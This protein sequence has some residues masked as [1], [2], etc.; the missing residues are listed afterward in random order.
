LQENNLTDWDFTGQDLSGANLFYSTLRR[1]NFTNADLTGASLED[2]ELPEANFRGA[3]L[4]NVNLHEADLRT[5]MLTGADL[6]G[7]ASANL[8]GAVIKNTIL[9]DGSIDAL[10]LASG[11]ELAIRNYEPSLAPEGSPAD[12]AMTVFGGATFSAGS[13][14]AVTLDSNWRSTI[15]F[16]QATPVELGGT[17]E[18]GFAP[19]ANPASF[20]G[21]TFDLFDWTGVTPAGEFEVASEFEWDLSQLYTAGDVTLVGAPGFIASDFSGDGTVDA[22]DLAHWQAGYGMTSGAANS[23]G[24]GDGDGDVDGNDFLLWQRLLTAPSAAR[25]AAAVP[26]PAPTV[27]VVIAAIM[28]RASIIAGRRGIN[29]SMR[30]R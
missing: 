30:C 7:A 25:L 11:D 12:I 10:A 17:L 16:E 2:V 8:T 21:R 3:I 1:A 14:L 22:A 26:E 9:P 5:A 24:D 13:F 27:L 4:H 6:R 18:L 20:V 23:Q 15:S 29:A 28:L 19:D